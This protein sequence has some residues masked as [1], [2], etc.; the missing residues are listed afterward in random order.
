MTCRIRSRV[1]SSST[2]LVSVGAYVTPS[3]SQPGSSIPAMAFLLN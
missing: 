2:E 3:P 1:R